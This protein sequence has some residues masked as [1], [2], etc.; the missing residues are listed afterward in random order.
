MHVLMVVSR[1]L[2]DGVNERLELR[3]KFVRHELHLFDLVKNADHGDAVGSLKLIV[4]RHGHE[5]LCRALINWL[6]SSIL[7]VTPIYGFL[8]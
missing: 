8:L 6:A 4:I 7:N 5:Q 3:S 2:Y 1:V